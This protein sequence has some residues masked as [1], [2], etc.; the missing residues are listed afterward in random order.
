[1]YLSYILQSLWHKYQIVGRAH[2]SEAYSGMG[3]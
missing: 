1:M 2:I 3:L